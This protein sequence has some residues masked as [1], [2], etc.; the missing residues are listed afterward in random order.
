M[1]KTKTIAQLKTLCK[2]RKIK[3]FSGKTK[4]ESL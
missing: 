4:K 2:E 3:G 1:D